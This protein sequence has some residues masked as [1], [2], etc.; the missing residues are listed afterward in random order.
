M[1]PALKILNLVCAVLLVAS[2]VLVWQ[3][4]RQT[5]LCA[6]DYL[7]CHK[8]DP[9]FAGED[10][11]GI[12]Y[13]RIDSFPDY[14]QSLS[15]L[16]MTLTGR[17]V[18]HAILQVILLLPG[19]VFDL[20]NTL[21]LFA[22]TFLYTTWFTGRKHPARLALWLLS[23]MLWYLSITLSKRNF[24]L[25]AFSINYLWTQVILFLF[26]IPL[27]RLIQEERRTGGVVQA[28]ILLFC[29]IIVGATN[30]PAIPG[31]LLA[32]GLWG[33]LA[34][35]RSPKSLPLWY[36][37]AT[38]GLMMGFIF[39]F[40]APGNSG[41][42]AY[43]STHAGTG[44]I[45]FNLS[46]LG[47]I[48][49]DLT[50][51]IPAICLGLWG[52][53]GLRKQEFSA[54]WRNYLFLVLA[55]GGTLFALF[56]APIYSNRMSILYTGYILILGLSFFAV[57]WGKK[58]LVLSICLLLALIPFGYRLRS[59]YI[60]AQ[61]SEGEYQLFLQQVRACPQD[62]C[63]V[64]P[65]AYSESL[66]R[67][68]WAEAV[69]SYYGKDYLGVKSAFSVENQAIWKNASYHLE[70]SSNLA[71]LALRF[72]NHD[73][74]TRTLYV[75][76]DKD[77]LGFSPDEARIAVKTADLPHFAQSWAWSIP[78]QVLYNLL[79]SVIIHRPQELFVNEDYVV[80]AIAMP[81][82]DGRDDILALGFKVQGKTVGRLFLSDLGFR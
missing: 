80:Y 15:Q 59:D 48:L 35:I 56:F 34:F 12:D 50:A 16:Y 31:V 44:G 64:N 43:E 69:A 72:V 61:R 18:P 66:T 67:E 75:I 51:S 73:P 78:S 65:R 13:E 27:R 82:E 36:Y 55:L 54:G 68:N 62:S 33:L 70:E 79:P 57:R 2:A 19:W 29:G 42:A 7:Y 9:G 77:G 10:P 32:L 11:S 37:T 30:E 23:T 81:I 1:S 60:W 47:A 21:A 24:Y 4:N 53:F 71:L 74:F 6:D 76:L 45:G 58:P 20:L 46:N 38:A 39:M 41:R 17:I 49:R 28:A 52:I 3:T 22:L 8:F 63:L 40:L 14:V 5:R 25:P 26:L